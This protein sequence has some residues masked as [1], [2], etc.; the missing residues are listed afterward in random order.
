M[1]KT[2]IGIDNKPIRKN[3]AFIC[4]ATKSSSSYLKAT[5]QYNHQ[6]LPPLIQM[7]QLN[8][9]F[10]KSILAVLE[11]INWS[12]NERVSGPAICKNDSS[13]CSKSISTSYDNPPILQTLYPV[14]DSLDINTTNLEYKHLD[15]IFLKIII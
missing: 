4:I 1:S 14:L 11:T 3:I 8:H 13:N 15:V 12:V 9:L 5:T 6:G 2:S 7:R 10:L